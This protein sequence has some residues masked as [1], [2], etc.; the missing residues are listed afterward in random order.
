MSIAWIIAGVLGLLTSL[1]YVDQFLGISVLFLTI[2]YVVGLYY[3]KKRAAIPIASQF[4]WIGGYMILLSPVFAVTTVA[5]IRFWAGFILTVL[6]LVLPICER[7]FRWP[8]WLRLALGAFFASMA[9]SIEFFTVSKNVEPG[10]RKQ[11]G[12]V[13][14]G[15]IIAVPILMVAG[16]LLASAD[17]IMSDLME[18]MFDSMEFD[19]VGIWIW[20]L[21][22]WLLVSAIVFGYS[23]WLLREKEET[24]LKEPTKVEVI[25]PTVSGT[26][27]VLLNL[28]YLVFAYIQIR[29]L[30][31]GSVQVV[32]G[33]YDFAEYARSGFFELVTLSILNTVGI[34]VINRFTRPHFFNHVSLTIT[35]ICTFLMIASSW[36][37]M[38]LYEQYYGY[39]QARLYVYMI[40]AFMVVFMALITLGIWKTDYKVVEWS[41]VIGLVYF[42]MISYV[43]VDRIIVENNFSRYETTNEL[44]IFYL[45]TDLSEDAIPA[46]IEAIEAH[47]QVLEKSHTVIG[48]DAWEGS[49]STTIDA[50]TLQ[51]R[52]QGMKDK[53]IKKEED[54]QFF[55]FNLRHHQALK[56]AQ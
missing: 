5:T 1:L 10:E 33:G 31:F 41:I 51:D 4:Y 49:Y 35:G 2:L 32:P 47:P 52:F 26:I 44:D 54:R 43:N 38:Y 34:L 14:L 46:V 48:R 45:M 17:Q 19:R 36:Y 30:F 7:E 9:R 56:A 18:K 22:V 23:V 11:I 6:L 15:V 53:V 24:V 29:F 37:K 28:L 3:Y 16:G 55:E 40:L 12:Y 21:I 13:I 42:L 20:R 25:P 27:L 50:K 39:T 8:R